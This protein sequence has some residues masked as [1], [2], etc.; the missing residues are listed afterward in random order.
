MAHCVVKR[1]EEKYLAYMHAC[2]M[3][4]PTPIHT[5]KLILKI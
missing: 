1:L 2:N 5:I 4:I 3:H